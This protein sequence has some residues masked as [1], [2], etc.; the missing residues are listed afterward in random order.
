MKQVNFNT[1]RRIKAP[2]ELITRTLTAARKSDTKTAAPIYAPSR[3]R[4][5]AVAASV[6]LVLGAGIAIYFFVRNINNIPP[7]VAPVSDGTHAP[8]EAGT[9]PTEA[10]IIPTQP[11]A[12]A[13]SSGQSTE[14]GTHAPTVLPSDGATAPTAFAQ[15]EPT[16]TP[17]ASVIPTSPPT[18]AVPTD[19][20]AIEPTEPIIPIQAP[21]APDDPP[22]EANTEP[23][24]PQEPPCL[25]P[26]ESEW[27][28]PHPGE[29]PGVPDGPVTL[30]STFDSALLTGSKKVYCAIY[31]DGVHELIGGDRFSPAHEARIVERIGNDVVAEYEAPRSLFPGW[32]MYRVQFYNE[33]GKTVD[34]SGSY[35]P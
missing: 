16:S 5:L 27:T 34:A 32:K 31:E 23:P 30:R 12:P 17:T 14:S 33:D 15:T 1:L 22:Y 7:L 10:A 29:I 25:T 8:I 20:P 3:R 6:A 35:L 19:P 21:T 13:P 26:T 11:D 28:D 9:L 2:E 4:R 24:E 18:V